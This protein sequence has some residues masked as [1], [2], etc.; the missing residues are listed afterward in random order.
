MSEIKREGYLPKESEAVTKTFAHM[1]TENPTRDEL[2]VEYLFTSGS[3]RAVKDLGGK[4]TDRLRKL[5][6]MAKCMKKSGRYNVYRVAESN[7]LCASCPFNNGCAILKRKHKQETQKA[8][9]EER[10]IEF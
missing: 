5:I 4:D 1:K 8:V 7:D 10:I 3:T 2:S 9:E 6:L